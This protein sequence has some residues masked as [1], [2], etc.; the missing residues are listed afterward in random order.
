MIPW[1]VFLQKQILEYYPGYGNL[2]QFHH[3]LYLPYLRQFRDL[4]HIRP[5]REDACRKCEDIKDAKIA[6][7][8]EDAEIAVN[9]EDIEDAEIVSISQILD[10][11]EILRP[12]QGIKSLLAFLLEVSFFLFCHPPTLQKSF[13]TDVRT[14]ESIVCP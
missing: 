5:F 6:E 14:K 13:D 2:R 4:R 9:A 8:I 1:S 10:M 12:N 3:R 11:Y 7:D